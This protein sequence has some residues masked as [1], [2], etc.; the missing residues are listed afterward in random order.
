ML[1]SRHRSERQKPEA[2]SEAST[3]AAARHGRRLPKLPFHYAAILP[4]LLL[5]LIIVVGP[6][7]YSV[8]LSLW[9]YRLTEPDGMRFV[10]LANYLAA[11]RDPVFLPSLKITLLFAFTV[12]TV[13]LLLGFGIALLVNRLLGNAGWIR[14]LVIAGIMLPLFVTPVVAGQV[15]RALMHPDL[16]LLNYYLRSWGIIYEPI[17]WLGEPRYAVAAIMLVDIWRTTPFMFLTLLAGLQSVPTELYEAASVDGAS[18]A[19]S[20]R[21][22]TLPL[23]KPLVIVALIIRGMD[24]VREFDTIYILTGGGPGHLTEVISLAAYRTAFS[25][26]N[27]GLGAAM[28]Y[29]IFAIILAMCLLFVRELQRTRID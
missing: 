5:S 28:S 11:L 8:G 29:V 25:N 19:Q 12:V 24:A 15:W 2:G 1:L 4:A 14:S 9:R 6:L 17:A 16:G 22:I 20:F 27:I 13:E 23:L 21:R 18:A 26:F 3:A 10:G 7:L